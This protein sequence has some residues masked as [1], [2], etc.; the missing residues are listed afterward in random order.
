VF[1]LVPGA[2]RNLRKREFVT[3]GQ[4][5]PQRHDSMLQR[6]QSLAHH[7]RDHIAQL[8]RMQTRIRL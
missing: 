8:Q 1:P 7:A 2:R 6:R 4:P 5:E 3:I